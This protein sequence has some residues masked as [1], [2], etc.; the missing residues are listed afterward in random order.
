MGEW[1]NEGWMEG[2]RRRRIHRRRRGEW[3]ED[4]G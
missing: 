3:G 1:M 4:E 2:V